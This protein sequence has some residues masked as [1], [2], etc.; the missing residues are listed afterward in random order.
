MSSPT[1]Q[2]TGVT[3]EY[4]QSSQSH[5]NGIFF[6]GFPL[7]WNEPESSISWCVF[8]LCCLIFT[9]H[10]DLH[11][12]HDLLKE[13]NNWEELHRQYLTQLNQVSTA[14]GLVLATAAVFISSNPPLVKDVD[15][16][17]DVSYACLAESLVFSLFGLLLQLKVSASGML[18]QKR[19]TA[20]VI[21]QRRWRIF[22][23]LFGLAV[24]IITFTMSV[25]LLLMAI[26]LTGFSSHS[27]TAQL[28]LSITFAFLG[29]C[30]LVAIL[31]SPFYHHLSNL[32]VSVARAMRSKDPRKQTDLEH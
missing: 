8:K 5:T 22:W 28:Y 3:S 29:A 27:K 15:Y 26:V 32:C 18:F 10:G 9:W 6:K 23:H 1:D 25:V 7:K 30:H 2:N 4:S 31:G 17:S 14:Q 11:W 24:P 20:D 19:H 16:T 12:L 21:I 13:G